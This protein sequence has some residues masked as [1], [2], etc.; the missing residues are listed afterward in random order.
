[1][2]LLVAGAYVFHLWPNSTATFDNLTQHGGFL[3]HG[4]GALF[5][6]VVVVIFSMTGVE[7]ATLAAAESED[8]TGHL[9]GARGSVGA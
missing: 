4:V 6:G 2:F 5:T 3:P 7:V 1:M 9:A 8:P